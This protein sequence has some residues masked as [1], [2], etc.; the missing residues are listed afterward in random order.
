VNLREFV[1]DPIGYIIIWGF[2]GMALFFHGATLLG[3]LGYPE[4]LHRDLVTYYPN[5]HVGDEMVSTAVSGAL[6]VF[7]MWMLYR[8]SERMRR[9]KGRGARG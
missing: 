8:I 3:L 7:S 9:G 6:L 4:T 1:W 5:L 2:S